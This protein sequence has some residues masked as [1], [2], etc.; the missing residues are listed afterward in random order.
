MALKMESIPLAP[1]SKLTSVL[2][3][4][5]I[6]FF[7]LVNAPTVYF[8][9]FFTR[10]NLAFECDHFYERYTFFNF[11]MSLFKNTTH[12]LKTLDIAQF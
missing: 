5:L 10:I 1:R 9:Y 4:S 3:Q 2:N 7:V 12:Y 8:A 11:T 6:F